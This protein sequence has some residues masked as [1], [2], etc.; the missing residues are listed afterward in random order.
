MELKL[1]V[2]PKEFKDEKGNVHEY[3]AFET[4]INGQTFALRPREADKKLLY[5]LLTELSAE[6]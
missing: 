2:T 5:Y 4:T 6:D 3:L 1:T